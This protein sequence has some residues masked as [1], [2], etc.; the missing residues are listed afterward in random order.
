MTDK[1][2]DAV[3]IGSGLGGLTAGALLA[4]AGYSVCL[5]ERNFS[6][7][8]AASVYK[9][10]DLA[11]ESS[12]HQTSDGRNPRDIKHA[13]LAKL[14]IL[15]EIEWLPTGPLY[16]VRGGPIGE[17]FELPP[18]FAAAHDALAARFPDKRDGIKR[19]LGEIE[20]IHD[21]LWTL[22]QAREEGS[23]AKFSRALW[24][25]APAAA[26]WENTL[27]EIMTR[28]FAGAEAVK[29]ALGANLI[30]HGDDPR[31]LWWIYFALAQGAYIASGG[32]Y[33]KGGSRQLSLKLA[34]VITR[35]GGVVRMGRLVTRIETDA[36]GE[37][38]A[39][40]HVARRAGDF[41]ERLEARVVMANCAPSVAAAMM[42]PPA[43]AAMEEAFG[44]RRLST[45]LFSANFGLA[46]KPATVGLTEFSTLV[47]PRDMRRFDQYADGADAMAHDPAGEA[48]IHA[49]ANFTAVDSQLWDEPPILVSVLGLDRL[50][51]WKGLTKEAAVDRRERWLDAIQASLESDYPGFS[52]LVTTRM[53]LNAYS[54]SSY[55][56][57]PEGAVY[58]FAALP[59]EE[60]ILMGFPRTPSTPIK[61][62]YLA[63][64]FGGEHGFNGAMLTGAEAAHLAERRLAAGAR[65]P[66]SA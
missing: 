52:G 59:P 25:L 20:T 55:L 8:G 19:F 26:G 15:D 49:I 60:P 13:I 9:I 34:K 43:R 23:L 17:A 10:G 48:P 27:D 47:L 41:E 46:A 53:L 31:R 38:V 11:I 1:K 66:A 12:L 51:N 44:S 64:A 54:M 42:D 4:H 28:D 50:D 7:G 21:A 63:S 57:T 22:K 5:L 32:A 2:F 45:S 14:G 16:K 65:A 35:S 58:G 30:F 33:I 40:R 62:L 6:L 24:E 18:G 61:G 39:I 29:C 37:A 36:D 3:V 56:N